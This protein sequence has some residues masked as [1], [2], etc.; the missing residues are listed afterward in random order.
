MYIYIEYVYVS[1]N[2]CNQAIREL[3]ENFRQFVKCLFQSVNL[4]FYACKTLKSGLFWYAVDTN[5][6]R[7]ESTNSKKKFPDPRCSLMGGQSVHQKK[8]VL[9]VFFSGGW[10]PPLKIN[11]VT[12]LSLIWYVSKIFYETLNIQKYAC[13]HRYDWV[14]NGSF[15]LKATIKSRNVRDYWSYYRLCSQ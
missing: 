14:R 10:S 13:F 8:K 6:F 4:F 15:V 5:L 9:Y 1:V 11:I 7:L 12:L 2:L 3:T